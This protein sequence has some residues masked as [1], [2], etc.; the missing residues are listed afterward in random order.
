MATNA[1]GAAAHACTQPARLR[2]QA[3]THPWSVDAAMVTQSPIPTAQAAT[4][5]AEGGRVWAL[6]FRAGTTVPPIDAAHAS[7]QSTLFTNLIAPPFASRAKANAPPSPRL[8]P[9]PVRHRVV[10]PAT[11]LR[12]CAS[13]HRVADCRG[14]D[15]LLQLLDLQLD[16]LH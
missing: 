5:A 2:S 3:A 6:A 16:L 10:V 14:S 8:R 13:R 9:C 1:G 7:T 4:Q 15:P 11:R 12:V